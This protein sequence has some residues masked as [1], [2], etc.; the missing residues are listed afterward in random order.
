MSLSSERCCLRESFIRTEGLWLSSQSRTGV[1]V[2]V[3]QLVV[4]ISPYAPLLHLICSGHCY[5]ALCHKGHET[6]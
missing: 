6:S 1:E 2:W 4:V 5:P 3:R